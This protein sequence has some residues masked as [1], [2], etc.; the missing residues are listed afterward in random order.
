[1]NWTPL[2]VKNLIELVLRLVALLTTRGAIHS[3]D[4]I[5]RL[6]LARRIP[7]VARP[8]TIIVML[9]IVVVVT[10]RQTVALLL[11]FVCTALHHVAQFHYCF[12]VI[13][14]KVT[15]E[16][17]DSN[18]TL[19]VVDDIVVGDVGDGGSCVEEALDVGSDRL[20]LL[21]FARG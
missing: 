7:L 10:A 4:C 13:T 3:A 9:P 20:A 14:P 21:L 18:A 5:V 1:M 16:G 19:E 8:S 2:I 12:A 15:V 17:L 6:A 11:L